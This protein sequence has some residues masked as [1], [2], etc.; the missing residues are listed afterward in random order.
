MEFVGVTIDA[1]SVQAAAQL[2]GVSEKHVQHLGRSNQVRYLHRG[3]LDGA[4]VRAYQANHQGRH[5][6]GWS[7]ETAWAAI[8]LLSGGMADWLGQAQV[9][10]LR[11]RLRDLD[12]TNLV[13][14]ARNRALVGRYSGHSSTSAR[15][16]NEATTVASR[17]L[18][19][20]VGD[21]PRIGH[22]FYV[23]IADRDRL[24]RVHGLRSDP[25]GNFTLRAVTTT[26]RGALTRRVT[27]DRVQDLLDNGEVLTALDFAASDDARERSVAL[28]VLDDALRSFRHG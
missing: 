16:L 7:A 25:Q 20:L 18:S 19:G 15:L 27:L 23:D 2:L 5:T 17:A 8:E 11:T 10:R 24:L 4:S 13:V 22:D 9:S 12:A 21:D 6:R 28:R 1:L 3:L 26:P 14:A